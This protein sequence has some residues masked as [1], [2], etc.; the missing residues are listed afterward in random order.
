MVSANPAP[1]GA[2]DLACQ[3]GLKSG[4]FINRAPA[5]CQTRSEPRNPLAA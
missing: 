1:I 4:T 2:V 5:N 3:K